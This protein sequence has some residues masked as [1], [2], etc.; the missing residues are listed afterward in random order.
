MGEY[1]V[2]KNI[3]PSI[4]HSEADFFEVQIAKKSGFKQITHLYSG[5]GA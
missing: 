2:S 3:S 5:M 1:L 4:G